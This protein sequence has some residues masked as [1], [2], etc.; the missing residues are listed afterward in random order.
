MSAVTYRKRCNKL[1]IKIGEVG[2]IWEHKSD[3]KCLILQIVSPPSESASGEYT[4]M[5]LD[6]GNIRMLLSDI[7]ERYGDG[8][9]FV[10]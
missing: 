9:R 10:A 8:W 1:G 7:T 4:V 3:I 2:E 6:T 5:H